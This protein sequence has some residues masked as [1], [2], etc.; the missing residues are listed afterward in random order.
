MVPTGL[1]IVSGESMYEA[2][3]KEPQLVVP[4]HCV[5]L[6]GI[7]VVTHWRKTRKLLRFGL[8]V[9]TRRFHPQL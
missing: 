5:S 7:M 2:K 9:Q 6:V 4:S 3:R 1:A 8:A